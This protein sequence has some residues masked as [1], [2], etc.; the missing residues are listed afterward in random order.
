MRRNVLPS[1]SRGATRNWGPNYWYF[2]HMAAVSY[3]VDPSP[4]MKSTMRNFLVGIPIFLPCE[5]C[6]THAMQYLE[7]RKHLF[8]WAVSNRNNLFE[9]TWAFHNHV[10]AAT[11]KPQMTLEAAKEEYHFFDKLN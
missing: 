7:S 6:R 3:P 10:N 1:N 8:D 4:E 9:F 5:I 2:I 11:K